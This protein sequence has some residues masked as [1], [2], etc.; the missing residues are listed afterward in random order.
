MRLLLDHIRLRRGLRWQTDM[1]KPVELGIDLQ[2]MLMLAVIVLVYGL[3]GNIEAA[4][5]ARIEADRQAASAE[6]TQQAMIAC[7]NGQLTGYY[8]TDTKGNRLWIVCG[9]SYEISDE[10]VKNKR[11]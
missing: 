7:L 1:P 11:G 2:N 4:A 5:E 10:N 3:V 6:K 9:E 8:T